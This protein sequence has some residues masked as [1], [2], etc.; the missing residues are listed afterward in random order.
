MARENG[1]RAGQDGGFVTSWRVGH[2]VDQEI[3]LTT[4][5][6]NKSEM[7]PAETQKQARGSGSCEQD[8]E[9]AR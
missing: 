3:V 4:I 7:W 8:E 2:E 9:Q 1:N 6:V 5:P